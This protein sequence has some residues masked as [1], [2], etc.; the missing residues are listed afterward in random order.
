MK[1]IILLFSLFGILALQSCTVQD[2]FSNDSDTI[3]EVF[4]V[5][6]T[7]NTSNN[8]GTIIELN[9]SIFNSDVVLVYRLSDVF[10]GQDVWKLVPESFYFE[11]GTLDFGYRFDF[12]RNDINVY[13]VGN[14]LQNV[15][16]EFRVNQVLR[17]VIIP[18]S[19]SG[20]VDTSNYNEV[21]SALK[22]QDKD[23]QKLEL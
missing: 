7:F 19:F 16:N 13:M 18:G 9:P 22:V 23:I 17:I 11:N 4:E 8:F 2:D 1:K 5:Q 21:I 15:A 20:T 6:R 14:N 10:E 3:S 12:T